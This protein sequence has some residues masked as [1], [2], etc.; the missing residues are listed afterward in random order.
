M[1]YSIVN[2]RIIKDRVNTKEAFIQYVMHKNPS[3]TYINQ[4]ATISHNDIKDN[5]DYGHGLYILHDQDI[6]TDL[7]LLEKKKIISQGYFYNSETAEVRVKDRW[8]LFND[9][10][11][12][13]VKPVIAKGASDLTEDSDQELEELY[14]KMIEG[15]GK[16]QR[17]IEQNADELLN[18]VPVP[19][20]S[21]YDMKKFTKRSSVL[22]VSD[23]PIQSIEH[24]QDIVE[25]LMDTND[26]EE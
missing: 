20:L 12:D 17:F 13:S 22:I 9:S 19:A 2:Q 7:I 11:I 26:I 25:Y 6:D 5:N 3:A 21:S 8:S 15:Y 14:C 16:I 24:Q 23:N 10:S 1:K 18:S 4:S